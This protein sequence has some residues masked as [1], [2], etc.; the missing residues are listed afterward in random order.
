MDYDGRNRKT[1]LDKGVPYPF[2]IAMYQDKLYW[3]D[4]KTWF[5]LND[6]INYTLLTIRRNLGG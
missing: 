2:G 4:W 3:T 5:V 6:L 1:I